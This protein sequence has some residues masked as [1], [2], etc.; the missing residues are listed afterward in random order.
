M[1][2]LIE[3]VRTEPV[4]TEPL[5]TEPVIAEPVRQTIYEADPRAPAPYSPDPAPHVYGYGIPDHNRNAGVSA[6]DVG[7]YVIAIVM[8]CGPLLTGALHAG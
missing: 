7:A 1:D 5:R 2:N 6:F 8:I 4:R 3:P